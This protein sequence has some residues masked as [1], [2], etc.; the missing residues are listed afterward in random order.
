MPD[1]AQA[2]ADSR[3][4]PCWKQR[5]STIMAAYEILVV[6]DGRIAERGQH[7]ELVEAGWIYAYK[8]GWQISTGFIVQSA[9]LATVFLLVGYF[10]YHEPLT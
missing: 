10:L 8:A 5:L 4:A 2:T 9:F 1:P 3:E 6:K 7:R